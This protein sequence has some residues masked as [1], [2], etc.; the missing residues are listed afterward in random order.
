SGTQEV[1]GMLMV[2]DSVGTVFLLKDPFLTGGVATAEAKPIRGEKEW[3]VDVAFDS[4]AKATLSKEGDTSAGT[5]VALVVNDHVIS[6]PPTHASRTAGT[7]AATGS[8]N[9]R[10]PKAPAARL[11][12][13]CPR[14]SVGPAETTSRRSSLSRPRAVG[15]ACRDLGPLVEL[16]VAT[17]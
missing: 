16:V 12:K 15:R 7:R 13:T 2:C 10:R 4:D 9:E 8:P 17:G 14:R 6:A 11:P 5:E 1:Q 3:F